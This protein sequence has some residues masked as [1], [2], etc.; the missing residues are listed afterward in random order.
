MK[1]LL[2]TLFL[3]L[4]TLKI[5]LSQSISVTTL[6]TNYT[7]NFNTLS[8]TSTSSTLPNGWYLYE[9]GDNANSTYIVGN[10]SSNAGNTYS[11]GQTSNS[12]RVL[13][14][15][16]SD[17]L[18]PRYGCKIT[19]NTGQIIE[20]ISVTY[21]GETWRVGTA[22]RIDRIDF[23]YSLN[24]TSLSTGTWVDFNSLDYQN[25]GQSTGNG[26]VLHSQLISSIIT[27]LSLNSGSSIWFRFSDYNARSSDDG[28]G[29]D[30]FTINLSVLTGLPVEMYTFDG[31]NIDNQNQINWSTASEHNSYYFNLERSIDGENWV[32]VNK[33]EG[34]GNSNTI[35]NY[36]CIDKNFRKEINYYRLTQV[37]FNGVSKVYGPIM[38]DNRSS[39]IVVKCVN[40]LGQEVDENTKGMIILIY[41]DGTM[42]KVIR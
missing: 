32:Y 3:I 24:A 29:I 1:N 15:L 14:G 2:L 37:D 33:V 16:R 39:K 21:T 9:S 34:A 20:S 36:S 25:P 28:M 40:T 6:N 8:S 5:T 7:E 19:N 35:I 41:Q 22:N 18:N 12:D 11:F 10:G 13:G 26:S 30:D 42:E 31:Y 17:N 23:S 4:S 38:I 27:G